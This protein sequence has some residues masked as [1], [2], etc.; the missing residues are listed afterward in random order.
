MGKCILTHISTYIKNRLHVDWKLS[1]KNKGL[2]KWLNRLK[3]QSQ[4]HEDQS[5][6]LQSPYKKWAWQ[7]PAISA[8]EGRDI[9]PKASFLG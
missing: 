6:D 9:N 7:Q 2:E 4:N 8:L 1:M 3:H 5:S